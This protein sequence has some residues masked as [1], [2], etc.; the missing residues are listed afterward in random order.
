[1]TVYCI[2]D[3]NKNNKN[4]ERTA[5][6]DKT[7]INNN[8]MERSK[9]NKEKYNNKTIEKKKTKRFLPLL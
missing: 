2:V 1:M 4:K 7:I 6:I 9:N 8:K 5:T 3:I